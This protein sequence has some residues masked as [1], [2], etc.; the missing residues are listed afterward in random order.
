MQRTGGHPP[1]HSIPVPTFFSP[2]PI[3]A[4]A[5]SYI[6]SYNQDIRFDNIYIT[7]YFRQIDARRRKQVG[8]VEIVR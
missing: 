2:P 7:R 4:R 6:N 3:F 8:A 1:T 5:Y